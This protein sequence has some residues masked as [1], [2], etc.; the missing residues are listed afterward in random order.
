MCIAQLLGSVLSM[1]EFTSFV[2]LLLSDD[3]ELIN[4][5]QA[6]H[7]H[8]ARASGHKYQLWLSVDKQNSY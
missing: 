6:K 5:V 2:L 1:N 3:E 4:E 7:Q 8:V